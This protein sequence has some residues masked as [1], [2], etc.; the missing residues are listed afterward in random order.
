MSLF[1]SLTTSAHSL[2]AYQRALDVVQNN[3][4]N[5]SSPGYARQSQIIESKPFQPE[6]G[7]IGGVEFG[8]RLSSRN[9][10]AEQTVQRRNS[11]LGRQDELVS[12][13]SQVE[14]L[15]SASGDTGIPKALSRLFDAF[16]A[17]S[18]APNDAGAR[19]VVIDR[20]GQLG[21][22]FNTASE[23]LSAVEVEA[24]R[25][26][27]SLTTRV[28]ELAARLSGLNAHIRE[29]VSAAGD[30]GLDAQVHATLEELSGYVDFQVIQQADRTFTVLVGGETPLVLGDRAYEIH[31]D[32]SNSGAA[33]RDYSGQDIT[34]DIGGGRLGGALRSLNTLLPSYRSSL[35]QLAAQVTAAVNATLAAGIDTNGQPGAALLAYNALDPASTLTVTSITPAEIAAAKPGFPGG[36]GN[37]LDLAALGNAPQI[38]GATFAGFYGSVSA[39][40][41][42]ELSLS[43][44]EQDTQRQLVAQAR[45][46]REEVSG[47]SLDEEAAHLIALQRSYQAA[48]RLVT[49]L[50]EMTET[51]INMLR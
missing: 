43:R 2:L 14:P 46:L 42:A 36:N 51:T 10:F 17:L 21:R 19:Q 13:L 11:N 9:G 34:A 40:V 31:T 28:N 37:A 23:G 25:Q 5:A 39:S 12:L 18:V 20:A 32:L 8:D 15:F 45:A 6:G 7:L 35:N 1:S 49:V 30:A 26:A 41:G 44:G 48:A 4:T 33:I 50:D 29:N 3:V 38:N 24:R 22:A 27:G 47:V 16:S